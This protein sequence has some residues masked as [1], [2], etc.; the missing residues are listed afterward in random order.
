MPPISGDVF[1]TREAPMGEAAIVPDG[2]KVCLGQRSM[3]IRLFPGLFEK[4]FLLYAIY[5]PSF[6]NRMA[7]SAVGA[8]VKHLRV[9]DVESLIIPVPPLEEQKRI[10]EKTQSLLSLCDT[11]QKQLAKSRKVAEQLAQSIVESITGISMEK[12][13]K[14]KSPKTELVSRLTLVK[15]PGM[16]DHAPLS[17]ILVKNNDELSAKELWNNSGLPI[18]GFYRQLKIEM[19]NG[20]IDEP[21]KAEI[22]VVDN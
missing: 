20:W 9:G 21:E 19:V 4:K 1:F 14:M 5:S 18:D 11:L 22:L 12:Q 10:V 8:T 17:A 15:K 6:I 16:E 2:E 7:E 13:E 3:L